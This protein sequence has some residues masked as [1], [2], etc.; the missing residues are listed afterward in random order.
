M[1]SQPLP[2]A[3]A[4]RGDRRI[5]ARNAPSFTFF[6][7]RAVSQGPEQT[8]PSVLKHLSHLFKCEIRLPGIGFREFGFKY[9]TLWTSLVAQLVKNPPAMQET[10]V[11]SL[12]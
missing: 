1:S 2:S 5:Q 11:Q 7:L 3:P 4:C 10:W 9:E 8:D 6:N 12:G